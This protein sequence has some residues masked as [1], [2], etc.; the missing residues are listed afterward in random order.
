M[1]RGAGPAIAGLMY[2][3][4]GWAQEASPQAPQFKALE[5]LLHTPVAVASG[6]SQDPRWAPA[7][8]VVLR[9]EDLRRRGYLDLDEVLHDLSGF[10]FERGF[11]SHWTQIYMR[12]Q[13]STNS[14]RFLF[15]WDGVIQNDIWAQVAWLERQ[16]PISAIDRIEVMYGPASLLYGS[17]AISGIISVTTKAQARQEGVEVVAKGGSF[18]TRM[19][20][21][22]LY[23]EF[24]GWRFGFSGRYMRTENRDLTS[25]T[26]TDRSG[27]QRYYGLRIPDDVDLSALSANGGVD[28][29]GVFHTE[30]EPATGQLWAMKNGYWSPFNGRSG[31]KDPTWW[32]TEGSVGYGPWELKAMSWLRQDSEDGWTTPQSLIGANWNSGAS[33]L[34]LSHRA[35]WNDY[36]KVRSSL[37]MRTSTLEP[38][39]EEPS[40]GLDRPWDPN[41]GPLPKVNRL[42]PYI[43]YKLFNR[44]Y[45]LNSQATYQRDSLEGLVGAELTAA[46][47]YENYY[48]RL[49]DQDPWRY[50]PQHDERNA[51]AFMNLQDQVRE[52][53]ALSM[54]LRFDHNWEAGGSGG[55][56]DLVTSRVALLYSP[57]P[58]ETW[59]IISGEG[60]QAPEPFKK[61]STNPSR[62]APSPDLKPERL[63]S[64]EL[65]WEKALPPRWRIRLNGFL[66][67]VDQQITLVPTV[68]QPGANHFENRGRVKI[69]GMEGEVRRLLDESNSLY[70]NLTANQAHDLDQHRNPGGIAPLQAQFGADL[71]LWNHLS[72]SLKGRWVAARL[73]SQHD[74]A[75]MLTVHS[76]D[77][78]VTVDL[79]LG[80]RG[81]MPGLEVRL[82]IQNLGNARYYDPGVRSADGTY[83]NGAIL[84][85]PF[86]AFAGVAYRF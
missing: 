61:Y 23:R 34:Q 15:L 37:L 10:D 76:V 49:T 41:G 66:S 25:E 3:G 58:E 31:R 14:D 7:K 27:R 28:R 81:L 84:Q 43:Q 57:N 79:A 19:T 69:L 48:T 42:G 65:G 36:W 60:F 8:V 16:F 11:G 59:K 33:S 9:S 64:L 78:Y 51:A 63:R 55:F 1:S 20:E 71:L 32:F 70:L 12:G 83:Y 47:V 85:Q 72:A 54:G 75:S 82:D 73:T 50:T 40:F 67:Q 62:P 56:G 53:L 35:E 86:R 24:S 21:L 38:T 6:L 77:P 68:G 13:R 39:T 29:A 52:D 18:Q 74:S 45:R 2:A 5:E 17:N 30:Y 4:L 44:E 26:W 46:R 80:W 22:S